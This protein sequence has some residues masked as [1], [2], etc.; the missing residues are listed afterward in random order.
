VTQHTYAILSASLGLGGALA[1]IASYCWPSSR[2]AASEPGPA[3]ARDT[4]RACHTAACAHLERPHDR[5][6]AGWTCRACGNTTTEA[7]P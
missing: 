7:T 1:A 2:P 3:P 4:Y 5:T 6:P